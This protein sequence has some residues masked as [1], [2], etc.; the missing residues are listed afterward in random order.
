MVHGPAELGYPRDLRGDGQHPSDVGAR[1]GGRRDRRPNTSVFC[2]ISP[3]RCISPQR[4]WDDAVRLP[5][6]G[7]RSPPGAGRAVCEG[8]V[9]SA[10]GAS[11]ASGSTRWR[12]SAPSPRGPSDVVPSTPPFQDPSDAGVLGGGST[13]RNDANAPRRASRPAC[14]GHLRVAARRGG[15]LPPRSRRGRFCAFGLA[16]GA[17]LVRP[18]P[19]A[20]CSGGAHRAA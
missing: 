19:R 14:F 4:S 6:A 5:G 13:R 8:R 15:G 1:R 9:A 7:A 11:T 16:S 18:G 20:R 17:Q 12:C 10:A 2:K 3:S